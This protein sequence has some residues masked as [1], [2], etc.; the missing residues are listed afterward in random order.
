MKRAFLA[1]L[2]ICAIDLQAASRE[3]VRA[4]HVMVA[5]TSELA[6]RIGADVMKKGGNAVDAAVAVALA[7]AV[8]WPSAGNLGGG[9]FLVLRKADGTAEVIDYRERAP[10]AATRTMY[11]DAQG[12][13]I[14]GSSTEGY[15]AVGVP[16]TV[17][18][19]MLAHKRHGK[20]KWAELV[21]P[22]RALAAD[23]FEVTYHLSRSLRLKSTQEKM[24]AFAE[25]RRIFQ[26][27]GKFYEL[28]ERFV[29][30]E[31]A[32]TLARIKANPRDFYEGETAR[33]IVKDMQAN[34][35]ILTLE[36]LRT[37]E[38]TVR[39]PLRT[40]YRGYEILTM[41]PPSSGGIALIEMLNILEAYDLKGM[42]WHSSQYLHTLIET[43]RRAFADRA[44]HLG[45]ADFVKVPL[46]GLASKAYAAERRKTIDLT[47]ASTSQ[48]VGA[49]NPLPYES[50]DTTHFT[51]VDSE[52]N[53]VS[54]TYTL[55]DSYGAGVTARGTGVLLNNEMDD[56][57]SKPG[58]PN[59]YGL[60]QGE[61]NAIQPK[62][63][64]LSSMTPT[65][66]T[67]NGKFAFAIGSPGGPTIINTVL[68]VLLNVIDFDMDIQQAI[69]SP[70]VHHQW[71]PDMVYWEA[72]GINADTRAV[73]EKMGHKFRPIPGASK[74]EPSDMGDAHGI[75]VDPVNGM[76]LGASDP[77]LGG[78]AV[79]W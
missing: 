43:M 16:G 1:L 7:L 44:Q 8:T 37:Y 71:M 11:L 10:L 6:S 33:L 26:R 66:V 21:E 27:D 39:K 20:L 62:K 17:A 23:G 36:D 31:L 19:L 29:Q 14:K 75:A 15:K 59:D 77:R 32:T 67:K 65:I 74:E 12:N 45:D 58:V 56:F 79:G 70:R 78:V 42:G 48:R 64:P 61:A 51:I 53:V 34:G 35:G 72:F 2:L 60:L 40:T 69:D 52:G 30:P 46:A 4:K 13:V 68:Q 5:S 73:L 41:P 3:P 25:S 76:R 38:P 28:G 49:A 18:G 63:R 57:T 22:A 47:R 55:N 9:G 50:P 54:N 24:A